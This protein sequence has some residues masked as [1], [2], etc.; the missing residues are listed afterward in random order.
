MINSLGMSRLRVVALI[1]I[2]TG[3]TIGVFGGVRTGAIFLAL[4]TGTY[5]LIKYFRSVPRRRI[6]LFIPMGLCLVL[7][8]V[9]LTLPHAK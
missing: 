1:L 3:G 8:G 4:G 6:E 2:V 7:F 9:A 5:A